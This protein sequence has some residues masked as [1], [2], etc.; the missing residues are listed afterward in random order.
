MIAVTHRPTRHPNTRRSVDVV[1]VAGICR[2]NNYHRPPPDMA[3]NSAVE[4][5]N[6]R[7]LFASFWSREK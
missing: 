6:P 5:T 7:L 3:V 2:H 4:M 1:R